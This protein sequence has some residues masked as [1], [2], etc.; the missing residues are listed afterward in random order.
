LAKDLEFVGCEVMKYEA[1]IINAHAR[2]R[3]RFADLR[4]RKGGRG[5]PGIAPRLIH[6]GIILPFFAG[7][8]DI[9]RNGWE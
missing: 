1:W 7:S 6:D 3:K 5:R 8:S 4:I 2:A 9:F